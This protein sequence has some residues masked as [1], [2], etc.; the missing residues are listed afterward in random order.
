MVYGGFRGTPGAV[1]SVPAVPAFPRENPSAISRQVLSMG[2]T[3]T[4]KNGAYP[5][6]WGVTVKLAE[7]SAGASRRQ[8][9]Q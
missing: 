7:T 2:R 9:Q 6:E 3:P 4:P 5:S 1:P 8:D